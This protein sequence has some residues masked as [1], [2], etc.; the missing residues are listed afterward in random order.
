MTKPDRRL[1]E[2][3]GR[4]AETR[5]ALWLRLKCYRVLARRLKTHAGEIDLIAL[6]PSR[7]LCF[8]EVKTRKGETEALESV[9]PKQ[10]ARIARAAELYLGAHPKLRARGVRFDVVV[11]VPGRLPK[12]LKDAWRP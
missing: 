1:S 9:S 12:N 7:I 11:I 6:S 3:G 4:R 2:Q 5:A 10:R 8:V